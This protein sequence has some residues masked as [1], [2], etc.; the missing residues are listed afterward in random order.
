MYCKYALQL[1]VQGVVVHTGNTLYSV[2][3]LI[4]GGFAIYIGLKIYTAVNGDTHCG[5]FY[6]LFDK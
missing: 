1:N 6:V 4:V 5:I 2:Y 3:I